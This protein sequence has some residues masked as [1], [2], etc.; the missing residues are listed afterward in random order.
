MSKFYNLPIGTLPSMAAC[1]Q[2]HKSFLASV[3]IREFTNKGGLRRAI[4]G[5]FFSQATAYEV[6]Q[7]SSLEGKV[8]CRVK[9]EDGSECGFSVSKA[10]DKLLRQRIQHIS[11]QHALMLYELYEFRMNQ[12]ERLSKARQ[13]LDT[14]T[15][16]LVEDSQAKDATE[17][18]LTDQAAHGTNPLVP[19]E[20]QT[21]PR[22]DRQQPPPP[23]APPLTPVSPTPQ[24]RS[25]TM[26]TFQ[27]DDADQD[28]SLAEADAHESQV[29]DRLQLLRITTKDTRP[30][31]TTTTT[32][33][34][35]QL[36]RTIANAIAVD[37]LP[38]SI[39]DTM[40]VKSLVSLS[41][42]TAVVPNRRGVESALS[43]SYM[44]LSAA[45]KSAF[46]EADIS[47]GSFAADIWKSRQG[48]RFLGLTFHYL[49]SDFEPHTVPLGI[50]F[51]EGSLTPRAIKNNIGNGVLAVCSALDLSFWSAASPSDYDGCE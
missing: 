20:K 38:M 5:H 8:V 27:D 33:S 25:L 42:P 23:P 3:P 49:S 26:D 29:E 7:D 19:A 37:S 43:L 45:A 22:V 16:V 50:K 17:D 10:T 30:K 14:T 15:T 35:E 48:K 39:L 31:F 1:R 34:S 9:V 47:L 21:P 40:L 2:A 11:S 24:D 18:T 6:T 41:N 4:H 46:L 44:K 13:R 12:T 28:Y 32:T 51:L 36:T